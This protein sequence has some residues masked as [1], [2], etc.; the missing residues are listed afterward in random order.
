MKKIL[1]IIPARKGSKGIKNKNIVSVCGKPLIE[2]TIVPALR[3]K[4][5]KIATEVIVSTDSQKI[6]DIAKRLGVNVPFLRP[7]AI[8]GDKAKSIDFVLHA[9]NYFKNN[10]F[11]YDIVVILQPTSPLRDYYDIKKA[12]DIYLNNKNDSLISAYGEEKIN[13]L[14]IYHKKNNLAIPLK[15]AHSKGVIRQEQEDIYIRNG[16]IYISSVKFIEKFRRIISD[17]P[18]MYAMPKNR[19]LNIDIPADLTMLRKI[20]CR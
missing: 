9:L 18:L 14:M 15:S 17:S 16:A 11:F 4:R 12:M 20:L 10:G 3:L 8:S 6:A 2:Y 7:Q 19:S 13:D 1:I 5:E